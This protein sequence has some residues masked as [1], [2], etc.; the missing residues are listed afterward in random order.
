M[1]V[2]DPQGL[3]LGVE[4]EDPDGDGDLEAPGTTFQYSGPHPS[5][6]RVTNANGAYRDFTCNFAGRVQAVVD[7]VGRCDGAVVLTAPDEATA[8][9]LACEPNKL[10]NVRTEVLRA[11]GAGEFQGIVSHLS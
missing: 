3:L 2:Q 11:Y 9:R 10:G 8:S 4:L 5:L 1:I 7:N 6:S